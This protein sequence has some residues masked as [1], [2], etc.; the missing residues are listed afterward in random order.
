MRKGIMLDAI[1]IDLV[2]AAPAVVVVDADA[3]VNSRGLHVDLD[4]AVNSGVLDAGIG[5]D[6][7]ALI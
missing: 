4:V 3:A 2:E 5:V 6:V 7:A 1:V